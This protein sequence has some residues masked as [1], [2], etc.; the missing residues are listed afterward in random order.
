MRDFQL[1]EAL[2]APYLKRNEI[3]YYP[4]VFNNDGESF[5]IVN[6]GTAASPCRITIVPQ[7]DIMLLQITGLSEEP[8]K[9]NKVQRGN[10]LIVDG[11][12]NVVTIDG[13]D[14]FDRYDAWEFPKLYA[15]VNN[16]RVTNGGTCQI[17]IEYQPRYV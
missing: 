4:V 13:K 14:A 1:E 5:S 3:I 17:S 2:S 6:N 16:V 15:G 8:I 7:N 10:V 11:I 9:I 12:D